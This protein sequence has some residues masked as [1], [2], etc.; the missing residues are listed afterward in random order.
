MERRLSI[1][2]M[3]PTTPIDLPERRWNRAYARDI[4][5]AI[6]LYTAVLVPSLLALG[7]VEGGWRYAI[8]LLPMI[9]FAGI[10]YAVA[11]YLA[12][13]DELERLLLHRTLTFAFFATAIATFG[14]GFLE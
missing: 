13:I 4:V 9:P 5:L 2:T 12:R 6:G 1:G 10:P 3:T 11:R 14:Y 8:A 7:R